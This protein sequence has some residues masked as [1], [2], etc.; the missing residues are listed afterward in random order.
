LTAFASEDASQRDTREQNKIMMTLLAFLPIPVGYFEPPKID[1]AA[2]RQ[3]AVMIGFML[4][5][6]YTQSG[7]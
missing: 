5:L 3:G 6:Q 4:F 7:H 2:T 1:N